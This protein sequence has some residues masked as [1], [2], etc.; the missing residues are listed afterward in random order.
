MNSIR[1]RVAEVA[2]AELE[3][4]RRTR[5]R[6]DEY[7]QS[8]RAFI[9]ASWSI[10]EPAKLF[11]PNWHI[12]AIAEHLQA[13][14]DGQIKDLLINIPPGHGKSLFVSVLWP[15]WNWIRT[16]G[17]GKWR[18]IF[19]SYATPLALRDATRCR[20]LLEHEWYQDTFKPEWQ[21]SKDQNQKSFFENT[22]KGS[23]YSIGVGSSATGFRADLVA[24]FAY[25]TKIQT[26]QGPLSIGSVVESNQPVQVLAF[27]HQAKQPRWQRIEGYESFEPR[28]CVKVKLSNG[29]TLVCTEDHPFFVVTKGYT[30]A[31]K[32]LRGD[33]LV[34]INCSVYGLREGSSE[35]Q[36]STEATPVLFASV[37][38]QGRVQRELQGRTLRHTELRELPKG[39]PR[40]SRNQKREVQ[41]QKIRTLLLPRVRDR[42]AME[43]GWCRNSASFLRTLREKLPEAFVTCCQ[44][45]NKLLQRLLQAAEWPR[46]P[47][48]Q[49]W[50][51]LARMCRLQQK[52]SA[53]AVG[54]KGTK[55]ASAVLF[56]QMRRKTGQRERSAARHD[57]TLLGLPIADSSAQPFAVKQAAVVLRQGLQ[58]HGPQPTNIRQRKWTIPARTRVLEV[59]ARVQTGITKSQKAGRL[60][61]PEVLDGRSDEPI[62]DRRS[63]YRLQQAKQRSI[64]SDFSLPSLPRLNAWSSETPQGSDKI[65][66][67]SVEPSPTPA[68]VYNVKVAE[69]HNYF[70]EGVLVHNCDDP[71]NAKDQNS[72]AAREECIFWWDQ[73]MSSRLND[74]N[75]GN[76][77]IIMQRLHERDLSGHVLQQAG[78]EHLRLPS[79]YEPSKPCVTSIGFVDPRTVEREPLFP[80]LFPPETLQKIKVV[81]GSYGF[82]GQHQQRPSP[83]EGGMFRRSWWRYWRPKG[84]ELPDVVVRRADGSYQTIAPIELPDTMQLAQSWDCAFKETDSSDYVVGQLLGKKNAD[85]FLI[86]MVRGR[87]D[88]PATLE[89]FKT[90]TAKH[91]KASA[92]YIEDK[93]NGSG[94]ISMVQRTVYG[95]VAVNPEG[96]KEARAAAVSPIVEAGNAY[97]PH[98]ALFPWV[99]DF[100]DELAQFPTGAHDDQVDAFSQG[101]LQM[102]KR[103]VRITVI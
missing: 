34:A 39:I 58:E 91:P 79:E 74:M 14:T 82:S 67:V 64:E 3:R 80:A 43:N 24:C 68:R 69:D 95:V 33:E 62:S 29:K 31:S 63:S 75:T 40:A 51:C 5:A 92:K 45:K 42:V 84:V 23:R 65:T 97:L 38:K 78:Y 1:E 28:P 10:V 12:D 83:E 6:A 59:S 35:I 102:T 18:A 52:L 25:D 41:A 26:T 60:P 88:F 61:L 101:V 98:P 70:A 81:L 19:A 11:I 32:L 20:A 22:L 16:P 86:D 89:A 76:K 50:A 36:I 49:G 57:S 87:M 96:G 15:A 37:S 4:R 48:I 21:F 85:F 9:E 47:G 13:V 90:F 93:A 27:D 56:A 30:K 2:K 53:K 46:K 8:F 103:Q 99:Q 7:R 100:I 54:S 66:I 71:L 94:I 77:V 73:V 72:E 55:E 17:S 44:G